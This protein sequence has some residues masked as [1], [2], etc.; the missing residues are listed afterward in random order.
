M[1]NLG[2]HVDETVW[3][4]R[5]GALA[6]ALEPVRTMLCDRLNSGI[7]ACQLALLPVHG[8]ADQ[9]QVSAEI[10]VLPNPDR[11]RDLLEAVCLSLQD[12]LAEAAG[13][14]RTVVRCTTLDP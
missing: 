3:T 13:G 4:D 2:I 7:P 11:T 8:R 6:D 9:H 1:P 5:R 12:M 10:F 14:A